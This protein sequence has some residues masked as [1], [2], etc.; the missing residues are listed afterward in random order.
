MVKYIFYTP[1]LNLTKNGGDEDPR[2]M[3]YS[4]AKVYIKCILSCCFCRTHQRCVRACSG[5]EHRDSLRLLLVYDSGLLVPRA[6]C[7]NSRFFD[8]DEKSIS[9]AYEHVHGFM[10]RT[11]SA[12][13]Q[14][15]MCLKHGNVSVQ[16]EKW[17]SLHCDR[18]SDIEGGT[19]RICFGA[20]LNFP[21]W[22][23]PGSFCHGSPAHTNSAFEVAY[24]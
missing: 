9:L 20:T 23:H 7:F 21:V 10:F 11:C 3:F 22:V 5:S 18:M 17:H 2:F 19:Q 6:N 1:P 24:S 16:W 15:H 12:H 4:S 14:K 8:L 13:R